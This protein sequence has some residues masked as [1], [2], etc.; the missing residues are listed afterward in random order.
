MSGF[1]KGLW[2]ARGAEETR[3]IY[4]EWAEDYDETVAAAG[5]ATPGRVA[6][7]LAAHLED[8]GAPVMDFGCGTGLSGVAL[9]REGFTAIDGTDITPEMLRRA[10]EKGVYRDLTEG[11][12]GEAPDLSGYAAVTATGVVSLG[13]A[14]PETLATLLDAMVPGALLVFSYNESTLRERAFL[15]ALTDAQAEGHTL[16]WAQH[17]PHLPDHEGARWATV[18]V[19]RRG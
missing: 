19:L 5:Y 1:P 7:A 2:T 12:S 14:P 10:R 13:A 15:A 4:A 6:A 16:L 18:Y 8:R 9:A 3:E 17:G 11:V